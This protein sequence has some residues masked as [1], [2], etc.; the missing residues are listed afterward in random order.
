M[1]VF[2]VAFIFFNDYS[3]ILRLFQEYF[4]FNVHVYA[5]P[6][7]WNPDDHYRPDVVLFKFAHCLAPAAGDYK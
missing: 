4:W 5:T 2:L 1:S 3:A 6:S 7:R